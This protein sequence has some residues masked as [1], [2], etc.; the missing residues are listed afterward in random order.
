MNDMARVSAELEAWGR[1]IVLLFPNEQGL[2]QF[3]AKE[4]GTL[5]NTIS[6]GIDTSNVAAVIARSLNLPNSTILPI[7]VIADSFGRIVFVSQGY[8][9]GIGEQML[10]VIQ[11]L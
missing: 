7:F 1:S 4:F 3:D 11:K 9:I 8:T 10:K 2:Q 5:P 6:Y